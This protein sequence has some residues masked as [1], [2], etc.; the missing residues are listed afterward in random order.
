MNGF[1]NPYQ[2]FQYSGQQVSFNERLKRFLKTQPVLALLIA[3]SVTVYILI[4]SSFFYGLLFVLLLYFGGLFI[5]QFYSDMILI[6]VYLAG[7]AAGFI[8]FPVMFGTSIY[9]PDSLHIAAIQG[10]SVFALLTFISVARPDM[11]IRIFLL[12][13]IRFLYIAAALMIYAILRKDLAGGG[14]HLV[15]VSG[16][17]IA[18]IIALVMKGSFFK[19]IL[20]RFKQRRHKRRNMKFARYET[21]KE[22]GRPLRDE[23]YNDIRAERQNR[24][25]EI[26]DK[27]SKSGYDSLTRDEKELLFRQSKSE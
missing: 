3:Q 19:S 24:I 2:Q 27:I 26:L 6:S 7:A 23:E 11:K 21:V 15:F 18:S 12:M 22:E 25:D 9:E 1:N 14:T 13:Q 10:S 20:S 4:S 17:M 5:R 16:A 8:A